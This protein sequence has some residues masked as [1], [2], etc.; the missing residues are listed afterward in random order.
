MKKCC[1]KD[2]S[3]KTIYSVS[4]ENIRA[5][6][7]STNSPKA[8]FKIEYK[9]CCANKL[10][11]VDEVIG[12]SY[13]VC[14]KLNAFVQDKI[15]IYKE[16]IHALVNQSGEF[17]IQIPNNTIG[18]RICV[19]IPNS[20]VFCRNF[21]FTNIESFVPSN[22]K[23][24]FEADMI[25]VRM[26][27][28]YCNRIAIDTSGLDH[29][30]VKEGEN[31]IY[32]H[33]LGP[34]RS[35][36]AMAMTHIAI[37]EAFNM[38]IPTAQSYLN[39]MPSPMNNPKPSIPSALIQATINLL[40]YLYPSHSD[41]LNALLTKMLNQI[42]DP[43][44]KNLG[45][46]VGNQAS[47]AVILLRSSDGS[48]H[49]EP[50]IGVDYFPSDAPGEWRQDPITNNLTALG[51]KWN[52]VTT[53]VLDTA[54]QFRCAAPPLLS[55]TSYAMAFD[56]VKSVG[57]DGVITPTTRSSQN[58]ETGIFWAYDGMP[59][60]CAPPRL[61]NQVAIQILL[62]RGV[63][64]TNLI[65]ILA[66]INVGMA[67]T[68]IAAWE[69]KYYYKFW[70]P[71]CAIRESDVGTGP[72][73]LGDGNNQTVGDITFTPLGA[74]VSNIE[75]GQSFTPP[76]PAMPSGHASFGGCIFQ[77]LRDFF[78]TDYITFT[79]V[80]DEFN[81]KTIGSD[82]N[83][84]PYKPRTYQKLS[85]AEDENGQSRMY[86]GIH[87]NFDKTEGITLGN[88]VGKHIYNNIY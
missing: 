86:I 67:D 83:V 64:T 73:G 4:I 6:L 8:I 76:F 37:F 7:G 40:I 59:S 35:S 29:T 24:D 47:D 20:E 70:R 38:I 12:C 51:A 30:P 87:F 71:V 66:K 60:L 80:S 22:C 75:S 2:H 48:N 10:V 62:D 17:E 16:E 45:I 61:Y 25:D 68:A 85:D 28:R 34:C 33:Q 21:S 52:E 46:V 13:K 88:A 54:D 74:P 5:D 11:P 53:F 19:L 26:M 55:D 44:T 79:F 82:G 84:R 56:E 58:T 49:S 15:Y 18:I 50:K 72:S 63:S 1:N 27:I 69:S 41:R 9:S 81:G 36:R 57:G 43:V 65:R 77:I 23:P 39:L 14:V 31:R 3:T 78:Q 32:G 42:H